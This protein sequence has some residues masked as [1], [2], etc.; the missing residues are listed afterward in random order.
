M[1]HF[2][3]PI[4]LNMSKILLSSNLFISKRVSFQWK[5]RQNEKEYLGLWMS[6][7]LLSS[8]LFISKRVYFQWKWRQ[9]E[10][11]YLGLWIYFTLQLCVPFCENHAFMFPPNL[12]V[13]WFAN[14]G[15][16]HVITF[17]VKFSTQTNK[18]EILWNR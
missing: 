9:N 13:N 16:M 6:K 4:F 7:I 3:L 8:N 12:L 2:F 10:R 15:F 11:E 17:K 5:W 18:F 14:R 1:Q